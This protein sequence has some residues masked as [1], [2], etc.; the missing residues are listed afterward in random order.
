MDLS[1]WMTQ[2]M[3]RR[4]SQSSCWMAVIVTKSHKSKRTL[5]KICWEWVISLP[6]HPNLRAMV[7]TRSTSVGQSLSSNSQPWETTSWDLTT[8]KISSHQTTFLTKMH[9][10]TRKTVTMTTEESQVGLMPL[11][12]MTPLQSTLF[13]F[14][15]VR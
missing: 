8:I 14:A 5:L 2:V 7:L 12:K 13:P 4:I 3:M 11:D 9:L 1:A 10:E 15:A 6:H